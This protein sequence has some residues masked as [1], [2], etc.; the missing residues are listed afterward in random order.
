MGTGE[1]GTWFGLILG[2]P[3]GIGIAWAA[4]WLTGLARVIRNGFYGQ[5]RWPCLSVCRSILWFFLDQQHHRFAG[6]DPA[7]SAGQFLSGATFSQ[8]Q[9]ISTLRMCS[10]R[11]FAFYPQ[12]YRPWAGPAIGRHFSD[13]LNPNMAILRWA[14]LICSLVYVWAAIILLP[15]GIWRRSGCQRV[16]VDSRWRKSFNAH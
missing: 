10:C 4:I 1:I 14:L 3:G 6:H 13:V 5:R 2:I 16:D 11:Y 15:G 12:Y 8:T 9:G 7:C